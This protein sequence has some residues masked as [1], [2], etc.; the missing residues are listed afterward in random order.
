MICATWGLR[1]SAALQ[2]SPGTRNSS[3]A[4]IPYHLGAAL[5]RCASVL[6]RNS[7]PLRRAHS[8]TPLGAF[9]LMNPNM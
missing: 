1:S 5:L 9:W 7:Q 3:V 4:L 8:V 6:T 2:C